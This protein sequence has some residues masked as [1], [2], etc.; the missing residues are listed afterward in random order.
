M[1]E[2]NRRCDP[3][4]SDKDLRHKLDSAEKAP[5][6]KAKGWLAKGEDWKPSKKWQDDFQ[7]A[8]PEKVTF[9]EEKLARFSGR[10]P[11]PV[12][13]AWL[14]NRSAVDPAT[15][16]ADA[17]LRLVFQPGEKVAVFTVE[18]AAVIGEGVEIWPDTPANTTGAVTKPCGVWFLAQPVDGKYH[19]TDEGDKQ[20]CRNHRAVT[21]W[22]YLV[23][24]SD[25]ADTFQWLKALVQLPLRISAIYTSASRS[26]HALVRVDAATKLAWDAER[27][28]FRDPIAVLGGDP[29]TLTAVRLTRLPGALRHGKMREEK[30]EAR[31]GEGRSYV[32]KVRRYEKFARPRLQK[33]L[34]VNPAP[35]M[36]PLIDVLPKRDVLEEWI[37]RAAAGV[38]DSDPTGGEWIRQGLEYYAKGNERVKLALAEFRKGRA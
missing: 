21:A 2:Y 38:A 32:R 37:G 24:E 10:V 26:V 12:D 19:P 30:V 7:V 14:A 29:K 22:R 1:C 33:L 13:L 36:T 11:Y 5:S 6:K 31:D 3:P 16:D 4:W 25:E 9:N 18:R 23:I 28:R 17:F 27:D 15:V 34:Y 35:D 20:S 8:P